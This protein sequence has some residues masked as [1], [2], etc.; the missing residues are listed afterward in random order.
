MLRHRPLL[1]AEAAVTLGIVQ[2]AVL[3]LPF[4]TLRRM[5]VDTP[6]VSTGGRSPDVNR[7]TREI[8][9]AVAAVARRWPWQSTCL[10]DALT[11]HAMLRR[12]GHASEVRVGVRLNDAS[13]ARLDSHAWL[14]C[15]GQVVLGRLENLEDYSTL[16]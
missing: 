8:A 11:A 5:L 1:L 10:S 7:A 9:Q 2:F 12:R 4:R 3:T 14:E 6:R 16:T 13:A 15:N